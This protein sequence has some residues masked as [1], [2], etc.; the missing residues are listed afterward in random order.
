MRSSFRNLKAL[1]II[2]CIGGNLELMGT[3]AKDYWYMTLCL[4]LGFFLSRG[5]GSWSG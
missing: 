3:L 1:A 4:P 5:G 2:F